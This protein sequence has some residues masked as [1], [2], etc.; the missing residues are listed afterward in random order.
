MLEK[1]RD[2]RLKIKLINLSSMAGGGS[3]PLL[4][5]PSKCLGILIKGISPN[6]I[7]KFMRESSPPIIGRIED[8][9]Y[10][11]DPRTILDDELPIIT[12]AFK[13]LLVRT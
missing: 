8:D 6:R 11:M 9:L 4:N 12:E 3:L 7:E 13:N 5:L 1:N 10:I 2:Q